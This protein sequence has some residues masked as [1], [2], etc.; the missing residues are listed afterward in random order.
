MPFHP[1]NL[2]NSSV[3]TS[4]GIIAYWGTGNEIGSPIGIVSD[5]SISV[6]G[7]AVELSSLEDR[8]ARYGNTRRDIEISIELRG[9]SAQLTPNARVVADVE[10]DLPI[11]GIGKFTIEDPQTVINLQ[12]LT[13]QFYPCIVVSK[14]TS[15][16]DASSQ[17][18]SVTLKPSKFNENGHVVSPESQF[19]TV[20]P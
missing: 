2:D 9:R 15:F 12:N 7:R 13:I 11:N 5:I 10:N 18:E 3:A 6:D 17:T 19:I 14:D 1:D 16:A 20:T 4:D 8:V